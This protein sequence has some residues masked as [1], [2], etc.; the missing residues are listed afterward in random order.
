MGEGGGEMEISCNVL[1]SF[2]RDRE[3]IKSDEERA[4]LVFNTGLYL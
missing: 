4:F 3:T 1:E 2:I